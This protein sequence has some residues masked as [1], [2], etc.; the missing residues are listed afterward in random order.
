MYKSLYRNDVHN[1][2]TEESREHFQSKA[3]CFEDQ[4]RNEIGQL[5]SKLS[6]YTGII[7]ANNEGLNTAF[8][9]WKRTS[10]DRLQLIEGME[11]W[12][13]DK[14]FFLSYANVS[15]TIINQSLAKSDIVS[16]H[17]S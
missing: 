15:I 1:W 9:A 6:K 12:T 2:S 3:K 17:S 10:N 13:P 8:A 7:I 16:H 14:L 4:Y 11:D 5:W